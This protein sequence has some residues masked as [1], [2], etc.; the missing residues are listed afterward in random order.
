L[1]YRIFAGNSHTSQQV[2]GFNMTN[3]GKIK[4]KWREWKTRV[5]KTMINDKAEMLYDY[6]IAQ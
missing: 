4:T 6:K 3:K 1:H 5:Y 2:F